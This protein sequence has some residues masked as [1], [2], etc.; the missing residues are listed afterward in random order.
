MLITEFSKTDPEFTA[1]F[2]DFYSDVLKQTQ[3]DNKNLCLSI[4]AALIGCHGL[5][6]FQSI[7]HSVLMTL[8]PVEVKEIIYQALAYLGLGRVYPFL[9]VIN[10]VLEREKIELPLEPQSTTTKKTRR[11][12]G[13]KVQC[14]IFGDEM[15]D[16]WKS[17]PEET[18]HINKWLA[19]NCFG[20]YYT[21]KGLD[22][23][24]RELITFCFLAAQGGCEPQ[25]TAHAL[26]NMKVGNDKEF[27]IRVVSQIVPFIDRKSVV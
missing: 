17:G 23:K 10:N 9:A 24:E 7:I 5:E 2:N 4:L 18:R 11:T 13:T 16:F 22:I 3:L 6:E 15:K 12:K 27:L 19:E 14:K 25:L 21:R 20:D 8:S 1:F 26:G